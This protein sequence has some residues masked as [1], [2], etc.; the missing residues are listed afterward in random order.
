MG[1]V[2][3]GNFAH[4][5]N[6][7]KKGFSILEIPFLFPLFTS[8]YCRYKAAAACGLDQRLHQ[9]QTPKRETSGGGCRSVCDC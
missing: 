7:I 5:I 9:P 4:L 1:G 6:H 8:K 3:G 2:T